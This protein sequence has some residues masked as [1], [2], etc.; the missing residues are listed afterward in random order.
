[1]TL[2]PEAAKHLETAPPSAKSTLERAYEGKAPPRAAIK[3]FC[4]FCTGFS[5]EAVKDCTGYTCPFWQY[6]PFVERA[7]LRVRKPKKEG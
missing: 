3:A 6:R 7:P 4:L 1:M 5:R 2:R